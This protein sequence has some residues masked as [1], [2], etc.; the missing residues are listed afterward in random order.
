MGLSDARPE[1]AKLAYWVMGAPSDTRDHA[2]DP[3]VR[4]PGRGVLLQLKLITAARAG[5][6][7]FPDCYSQ[8]CLSRISA[9]CTP[10]KR[11]SE[12]AKSLATATM[13][14]TDHQA[15]PPMV[16]V[17]PSAHHN[18]AQPAP[19]QQELAPLP[20]KAASPVT[21]AVLRPVGMSVSGN[22]RVRFSRLA[23]W[24]ACRTQTCR[25]G[26]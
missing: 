10:L 26:R 9:E 6:A 25:V 23:R 16:E 14:V 20:L 1:E 18:P 17:D 12:P 13:A 3:G 24:C 2:A 22:F 11:L 19:C 7:P 4:L 8:G 5:P 21:G 15:Q